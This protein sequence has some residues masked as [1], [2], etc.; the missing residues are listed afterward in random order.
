MGL[1]VLQTL[2][3][4]ESG[5]VE[6]GTVEVAKELVR[7]G[8]RSMVISAGGRLTAELTASGSEHIALPIG[9][10]NPFTLRLIPRLRKLLQQN[11]VDI[12]HSRSRLPA[13]ISW[14]AWRGMPEQ[15]RPH[16]IT[17]VHGPY[18]VNRYSRIM[19]RGEH[20]IAV[21]DFIKNYIT[22]N[23]PDCDP[24]RIRVIPRGVSR[25]AFPYG[26]Q[27]DTAWLEQWHNDLPVLRGKFV[28]TLP[29]RITR[30]KGQEDFI[31]IL[32]VLKQE[33]L[34]FH[35]LVVGGVE[36]RR[37][38]FF[39]EL[40]ALTDER[41]LSRYVSFLGHRDDLKQ[42]MAASQL[43]VSLAREPEAFGRTALEAL[44]LGVPVVAYDHG[45][46]SE[47]LQSMFPQGLVPALDMTA[48]AN[49]I[50]D[51]QASPPTVDKQNAFTLEAMLD[52]TLK[53]Y[54]ECV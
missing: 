29:A 15:A 43:V 39:E 18:T 12:L 40:K 14:S 36:P 32:S 13:W 27:P 33:S 46:A 3:A 7:R 53:L 19:T 49:K 24:Q 44:S 9:K 25:K 20:V 47:V 1:T 21:S 37:R 2:P 52:S 16:F 28:I 6:R 42:I 17:S 26:Y 35:A 30:W 8:H 5:G 51:F 41:G 34:L 45:G 22:G 54:E 4:L 48:A 50:K 10:K 31:N 23:Y 38:A 11:Q